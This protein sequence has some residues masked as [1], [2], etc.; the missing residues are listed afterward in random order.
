MILCAC[1][2]VYIYLGRGELDTEPSALTRCLF[3]RNL[4]LHE[5][6]NRKQTCLSGKLGGEEEKKMRRMEK[7]EGEN[8]K[9]GQKRGEEEKMSIG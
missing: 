6:A 3:N 7:S 1:V 4:G 8:R 9:S 5:E 2:S